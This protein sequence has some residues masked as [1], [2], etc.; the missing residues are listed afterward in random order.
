MKDELLGRKPAG[1]KP[2][3]E[4]TEEEEVKAEAYAALN[5]SASDSSGQER[6]VGQVELDDEKSFNSQIEI[7][8]AMLA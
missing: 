7:V 1:P 4:D 3:L 5:E 2:P 6:N 8:D